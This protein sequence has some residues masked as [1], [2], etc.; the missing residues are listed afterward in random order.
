MAERKNISFIEYE[1][2]KNLALS[3]KFLQMWDIVLELQDIVI[4]HFFKGL[5]SR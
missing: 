3:W 2:K 1:K 4:D 5:I